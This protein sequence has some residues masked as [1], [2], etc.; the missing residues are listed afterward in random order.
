M[1][2]PSGL[3]S[4]LCSCSMQMQKA[5]SRSNVA[6]RNMLLHYRWISLDSGLKREMNSK[7]LLLP[8]SPAK[9]QH[10]HR[11]NTRSHTFPPYN[12][13][14][15][16]LTCCLWAHPRQTDE[17]KQR[18]VKWFGSM[19]RM[20][21]SSRLQPEEW[22][23]AIL[24]YEKVCSHLFWW[25]SGIVSVAKVPESPSLIGAYPSALCL[26]TAPWYR[27]DAGLMDSPPV[28]CFSLM[29][30][31]VSPHSEERLQIRSKSEDLFVLS[32]W[33]ATFKERK[34]GHFWW[35]SGLVLCGRCVLV[36]LMC[37]G[38]VGW[39]GFNTWRANIS[40]SRRCPGILMLRLFWSMPKWQRTKPEAESLW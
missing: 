34:T 6:Q 19:R 1:E 9:T 28:E 25:S 38:W 33:G 24:L 29:W 37:S 14:H 10:F 23:N 5:Q 36:W 31:D 15:T 3:R 7:D 11:S 26:R 8:P 18:D 40:Q 16:S 30:V 22:R 17:K 2:F 21:S 27:Q 35:W 39:A 4:R 32:E 12:L 13:T 20:T